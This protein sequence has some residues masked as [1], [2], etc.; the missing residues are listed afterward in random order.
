[1]RKEVSLLLLRISDLAAE[2]PSISELVLRRPLYYV[3][4]EMSEST[5]A[6]AAPY[7]PHVLLPAHS[8][9][10]VSVAPRRRKQKS[11]VEAR[12]DRPKDHLTR[13]V[14]AIAMP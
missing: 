2:E 3:Y 13:P 4:L 12:H 14:S 11:M 5:R 10:M 1:M 7:E 6:A 8:I 9:V